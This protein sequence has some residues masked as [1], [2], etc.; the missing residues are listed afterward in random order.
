VDIY[1]ILLKTIR[2]KVIA[3]TSSSFIITEVS[4]SDNAIWMYIQ[5]AIII[6]VDVC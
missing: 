4:F 3:Y 2:I 5:I 1:S 6:I